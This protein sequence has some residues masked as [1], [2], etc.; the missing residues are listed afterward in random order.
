[1]DGNVDLLK[2]RKTLGR[3]M[4]R[5]DQWADTNGMRFNKSKSYKSKCRTQVGPTLESQHPYVMLQNGAE[6]LRTA[7]QKR[8]WGCWLTAT[9]HKPAQ[10]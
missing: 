9:E 2:G 7:Q 6:S 1:M 3:D 10:A 5:V 8:V 4:N